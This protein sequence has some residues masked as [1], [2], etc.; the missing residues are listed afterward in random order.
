MLSAQPTRRE[1]IQTAAVAVGSLFLPRGL[2]ANE[3]SWFV[4]TQTGE[5]WAVDDPVSWCL[6][7]AHQ[8][9]LEQAQQGL[10]NLTDNDRDRVIRLVTRRCSLNLIEIIS[11]RVV[12]HHW[13]QNRMALSSSP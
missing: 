12:V 6:H 1:F 3:K 4:H 2:R 10:L 11:D 5:S 13:G 8:P 7:N 9:I